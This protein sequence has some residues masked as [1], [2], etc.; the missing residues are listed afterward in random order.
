MVGGTL[1]RAEGARV[2]G[3]LHEIG[4]GEL[5]FGKVDVRQNRVDE[6]RVDQRSTFKSSVCQVRTLQVREIQQKSTKVS[7]RA[8]CSIG[9]ALPVVPAEDVGAGERRG[10]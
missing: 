9:D 6:L 3:Q 5:C 8:C 2:Q 1:Q 10:E 4:I 7:V